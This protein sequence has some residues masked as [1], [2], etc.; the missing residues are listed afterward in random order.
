MTALTWTLL[1]TVA[2]ILL[3][4]VVTRLVWQAGAA[5]VLL[6]AL[7]VAIWAAVSPQPH[8][9]VVGWLH[10]AAARP[11][12]RGVFYGAAIAVALHVAVLV[13]GRPHHQGRAYR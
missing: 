10:S 7:P 9:A 4:P 6:P 11:D 1:G 5:F 13:L 2:V 12:P 8:A 3:L